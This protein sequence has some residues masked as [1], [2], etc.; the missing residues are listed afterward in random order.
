MSTATPESTFLGV[1]SVR[2]EALAAGQA[3]VAIL[4]IRSGF[5]TPPG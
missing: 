3:D 4:G 1:P 2:A 5:R